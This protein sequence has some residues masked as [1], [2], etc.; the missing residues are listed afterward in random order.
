M[1]AGFCNFVANVQ[2]LRVYW[3]MLGR[4]SHVTM[5]HTPGIYYSTKL[6]ISA[7]QGKMMAFIGDWLETKEPTL[8]C[9]PTTKAWEWHTGNTIGDFKNAEL[10]YAN[11]VNKETLLTLGPMTAPGLQY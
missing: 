4:Q 6:S 8:A 9:L 11:E 1:H 7:Y 3:G 10:H 2:Q 5:I